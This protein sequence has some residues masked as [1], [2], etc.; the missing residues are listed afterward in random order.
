M[1]PTRVGRRT[2][3]GRAVAHCLVVKQRLER[4][5]ERHPVSP[6]LHRKMAWAAL[7]VL[8]LIVFTGAAVRLTGSGL[9][10]PTWPKCTDESLVTEQLG[11][12]EAI[13]FG[14][15]LATFFV[16]V[17]SFLAFV[18]AWLRRP[19]RKDLFVLSGIVA[20]TV[21]A[22]AVLGGITVLTGLNPYTVMGH[23]MLSMVAL[24]FAV[25]VVWR[26]TRERR[27][28]SE[29]PRHGRR[30][31]LATRGLGVYGFLVLLMG[32]SATAA[33][34]HAGGDG[35]GDVVP[36]LD[37]KGADTL[38]FV[39][40]GHA[41]VA[42]VYGVLVVALW[43]VARRARAD[44]S[45]IRALTFVALAM[46]AQGIIGNVQYHNELPAETVWVHVALAAVMWN[47]IVWSVL[48][49]GAPREESVTEPVPAVEASESRAP[50]GAGA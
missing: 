35:T 13:E 24:F 30:L 11:T 10:C 25:M 2:G 7:G 15:R 19:F 27:G 42:A 8:T 41:R 28:E 31:V 17:P 26:T 14:N 18:F 22:Q 1:R 34:P 4:F 5:R 23:F 29:R 3:D 49:A 40:T 39:I 33:G 9:G 37:F 45:L 48:A 36:R 43:W 38:D 32:T 47:A 6:D 46:A 50:A 20:V 21:P 16:G 44:A 12:H